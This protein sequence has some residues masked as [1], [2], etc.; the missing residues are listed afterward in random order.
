MEQKIFYLFLSIIY[1]SNIFFID[2]DCAIYLLNV[3]L[4]VSGLVLRLVG[5]S[6]YI[7]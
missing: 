6:K 4:P 5:N 2:N 3:V 1:H 7:A